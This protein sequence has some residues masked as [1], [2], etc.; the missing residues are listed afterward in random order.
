MRWV[1]FAGALVLSGCGQRYTYLTCE[2]PA[3][4]VGYDAIIGTLNDSFRINDAAKTIESMDSDGNFT[5]SGDVEE[6]KPQMIIAK[7]AKTAS[8]VTIN[9]LSGEYTVEGIVDEGGKTWRFSAIGKCKSTN[10]KF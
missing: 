9:R 10:P 8:T 1:I 2:A 3:K 4:N 6:F 7:T 5:R